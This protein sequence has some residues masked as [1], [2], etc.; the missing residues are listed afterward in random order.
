M[1]F[2][3]WISGR[4][5]TGDPVILS[6]SALILTVVCDNTGETTPRKVTRAAADLIVNILKLAGYFN[7]EKS[8]ELFFVYNNL[9]IS[10]T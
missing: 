1:D 3:F 6:P 4:G 2:L 9:K 5:H 7:A 10:P 8:Y